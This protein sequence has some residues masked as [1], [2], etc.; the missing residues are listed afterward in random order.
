[1]SH[2]CPSRKA[3]PPVVAA[4]YWD[5]AVAASA[6]YEIRF[7]RLPLRAGLIGDAVID[8][9]P[10]LTKGTELGSPELGA[11]TAG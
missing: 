2:L 8:V 4:A 7:D 3:Q 11:G 9:D 5:T 6:F 1:M 10:D